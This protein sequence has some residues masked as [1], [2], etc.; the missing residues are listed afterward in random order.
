MATIG[1]EV[2]MKKSAKKPAKWYESKEFLAERWKWYEKLK[3][4]GFKDIEWH[5]RSTGEALPIMSGYSQ[6]DAVRYYKP[7]QAELFRLMTVHQ[8]E[9]DR[10]YGEKSWQAKVWAA[11]ADGLS[12]A[13]MNAK[14]GSEVTR[15]KMP[16]PTSR[17]VTS[18]LKAEQKAML[19]AWNAEEPEF[20][21]ETAAYDMSGRMEYMVRKGA[22]TL[23]ARNLG[24]GVIASL[25]DDPSWVEPVE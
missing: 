3:K 13:K 11:F 10:K 25:F 5:S 20:D 9:V 21:R 6:M 16:L 4:A 18:W 19:A 24:D 7:D 14:F 1:V 23:P 12:F 22:H 2:Y 15:G 17:E 8:P